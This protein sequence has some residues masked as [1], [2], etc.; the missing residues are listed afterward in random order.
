MRSSESTSTRAPV[1]VAFLHGL[2]RRASSLRRLRRAIAAAGYATWARSY[3]STRA[4]LQA[5]A[6]GVS[7]QLTALE[8][9]IMLV[10]HSLGG[11][12]ARHLDPALPIE[13]IVMLAPPN[14]GSAV[15]RGLADWRLFRALY[16][17]AGQQV[18]RAGDAPAWPAPPAPTGIIA[19]TGGV[20]WSNPPSWLIKAL[21]LL[22]RAPHDG[23]V[24]VAEARGCAHVDFATVAT[25]HS[26]IM[27]HA[28]TR[29]LVLRFLATG[30]F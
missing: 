26:W 27:N 2:G 6:Q 10:T 21:G 13:R 23:T 12:V 15:A 5:I 14:A 1:T 3:P 19:G 18:G 16:G 7:A 28:R 25:G 22:P 29:E 17:P 24:T 20:S 4:D 11:I 9:P 8:T 30:S